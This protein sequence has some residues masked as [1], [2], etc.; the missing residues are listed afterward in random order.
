MRKR[1]VNERLID[2]MIFVAVFGLG[3]SVLLLLLVGCSDSGTRQFNSADIESPIP[4][5]VQLRAAY[6]LKRFYEKQG[7]KATVSQVNQTSHSNSMGQAVSRHGWLVYIDDFD[8]TGVG[9]MVWAKYQYK[10]KTVSALHQAY[11][12]TDDAMR[13]HGLNNAYSDPKP[14]FRENYQR[15][16]VGQLYYRN[17]ETEE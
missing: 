16:V 8:G 4:E 11:V 17:E 10:H 14:V 12:R 6:V 1:T 2:L 3:I 5:R 9:D 15:T 13:L 7:Y